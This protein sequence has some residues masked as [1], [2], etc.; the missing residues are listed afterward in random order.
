MYRLFT[1][2]VRGCPR[3]INPPKCNYS[4]H[5]GAYIFLYKMNNS[6][7]SP[8]SL[9]WFEKYQQINGIYLFNIHQPIEPFGIVF[10]NNSIWKLDTIQDIDNK[11]KH[12]Y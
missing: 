4:S 7:F 2:G 10:N 11:L 8:K 12:P 3:I 6:E 9:K 1:T 5:K